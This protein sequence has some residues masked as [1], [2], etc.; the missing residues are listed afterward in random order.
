MESRKSEDSQVIDVC[1]LTTSTKSIQYSRNDDIK[2]SK[3]ISKICSSPKTFGTHAFLRICAIGIFFIVTIL[4]RNSSIISIH[5]NFNSKNKTSIDTEWRSNN[6]TYGFLHAAKR[7]K[8][9][10]NEASIDT[11]WRSNNVTYGFLHAAKT[12]GSTIN[13]RL[14]MRYERVCGNKGHSQNILEKRRQ[15]TILKKSQSVLPEEKIPTRT[16]KKLHHKMIKNQTI[17]M[18]ENGINKSFMYNLEEIGFQDCDYVEL[19]AP[20]KIWKELFGAWH[21][22]LELHVPCR[23]PISHL[24]S[25]CNH[26]QLKFTC[27]PTNFTKQVDNCISGRSRFSFQELKHP[28]IHL[29][30]FNSPN[31]I[32]EYSEYMRGR[33]QE[34][35]VFHKKGVYSP[36]VNYP[37]YIPTRNAE[38]ECIWKATKIYQEK[39]LKYLKEEIGLKDYYSFCDS[40]LKS[41]NDLLV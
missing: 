11:G 41:V 28:N 17:V 9:S 26:R 4:H 15:Q 22:P 8:K 32:N 39:I 12:G 20:A 7:G 36:E 19:E 23:D 38:N 13:K 40:C 34:K 10:K 25:M 29:K 18:E 14:A 1:Q 21:R 24:L 6:V 16:E 33:L 27:E 2:E 5:S 30:C 3:Q 31:K 37:E 35:E